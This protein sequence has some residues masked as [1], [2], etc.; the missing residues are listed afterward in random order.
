VE[1]FVYDGIYSSHRGRRFGNSSA[2]QPGERFVAFI[3]NHDQIANTFQGS[4]LSEIV[5]LE[6]YKVAVALLFC[7]PYLPLL[8]MGEEFADR[9]PFL[10][11]TSHTDPE[12]AHAVSEGRRREFADFAIAGVFHDP[13]SP[14]TFEE[15]KITWPLLQ[16]SPH[17]NVLRLYRDLI[18][19]RK[20]TPCLSNGRKDLL[21]VDVDEAGR[22]LK[23]ERSDPG[24]S[25]ALLTCNFSEN[26]IE[27]VPPAG[28][29]LAL[30]TSSVPG[31]RADLYLSN[32][33]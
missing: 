27:T 2:D 13:Q 29:H 18:S 8:F 25:R 16:Q 7:S 17:A 33:S 28:W 9:A 30:Q 26:P 11:F 6:Q 21:R 12:L 19:L 10:Y 15:S 20:R 1:G 5:S 31:P 14:K 24:G 3:Q 4:R 32:I 22:W 23:M